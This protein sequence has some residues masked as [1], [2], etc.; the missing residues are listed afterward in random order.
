[1]YRQRLENILANIN[2]AD[3]VLN[4]NCC[5]QQSNC[6]VNEINTFYDKIV[7]VCIDAATKCFTISKPV[8]G[9]HTV[10]WNHE[11]RS[12]R[13]TALFWHWLWKSNNCPHTGTYQK[14]GDLVEP[15]I[16]KQLKLLKTKNSMLNMSD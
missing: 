5:N 8:I 15:G 9:K 7:L 14:L 13:E 2:L 4:C 11:I 16:T 10:P 12:L 3:N 1:M 6:H